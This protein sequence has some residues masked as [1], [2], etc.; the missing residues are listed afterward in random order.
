MSSGRWIAF[1]AGLVPVAVAVGQGFHFTPAVGILLVLAACSLGYGVSKKAFG[2]DE[3]VTR[4]FWF[5]TEAAFAR[6]EGDVTAIWQRY[7]DGSVEW[8]INADTEQG[9]TRSTEERFVH[10]AR[11]AGAALARL[12]IGEVRR[13]ELWRPNSDPADQWLAAMMV[14]VPVEKWFDLTTG[15]DKKGEYDSGSIQL[16]IWSARDLCARLASETPI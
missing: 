3:R 10:E 8:F 9:G 14:L 12:A 2:R 11:R 4:E 16:V 15:R 5:D 1:G 13:A 6:I 7:A